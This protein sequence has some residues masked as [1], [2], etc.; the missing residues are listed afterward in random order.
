MQWGPHWGL[1]LCCSCRQASLDLGGQ[2]MQVASML[3]P[4]P[5]PML[6]IATCLA[7]LRCQCT[8]QCCVERIA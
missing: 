6:P 7:Y 5:L 2:H 4:N 3:T 8:T 1:M